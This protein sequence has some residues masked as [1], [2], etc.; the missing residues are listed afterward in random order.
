[1]TKL[2]HNVYT[3]AFIANRLRNMVRNMMQK[4]Y[5]RTDEIEYTE[6]GGYL[7]T[8]KEWHQINS[9]LGIMDDNIQHL[10]ICAVALDRFVG[11]QNP[12]GLCYE[13]DK[14]DSLFHDVQKDTFVPSFVTTLEEIKRDWR[15][16]GLK[17][18]KEVLGFS[19]YLDD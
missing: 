9:L 4:L 15:L 7:L 6:R 18:P 13:Q 10:A 14:S 19:S 17:A 3:S 2:S 16:G 1:M 11:M 12:D 8:D 5:D